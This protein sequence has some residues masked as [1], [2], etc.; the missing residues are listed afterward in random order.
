MTTV[1]V[2][3]STDAS[4]PTLT[5]QAG[6]LTTLL[7]AVLVNGYGSQPAAGWT[8]AF[9]TTSK[10][11]YRVSAVDGT[12]FYLNVDDSAVTTAKEAY[13]T[14]FETMSAFAT[15]TG[16]FPT[17]SLLNLG[18]SPAGAVVCRKSTT[19][20]STARA[21]TIV[22]DDTC[23]YLFAETGDNTSPLQTFP[24]MFGDIFSYKSSDAYRCMIIGRNIANSA[25]LMNEGFAQL[26]STNVNFLTLTM[27]GHYM[28]R[29]WTTAG[30][31]IPFGK[32][33]DHG[34]MGCFGS[35]LS[36]TGTSILTEIGV[37]SFV[38]QIGANSIGP[39]VLAYPNGP[40]GGLYLSPI[41][42]HHSGS[43]R[44]YLK[45]LWAPLHDRPLNHDDTYSGTGNLS[46]KSFVVQ[47][48][49]SSIPNG[50]GNVNTALAGQV[51]IETSS[52]WS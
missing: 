4:A 35:N 49:V 46:G 11:S 45:G 1:T 22:A 8:I 42:V 41:W 12:G 39:A 19:A 5:G 3:R 2:Y 51:H 37:G 43:V 48:I 21:W 33:I 40:D 7:D 16:Q 47:S 9:T 14:G 52:T 50:I 24:F 15:G 6:S 34:K 13:M 10:R 29:S 38:C 27:I 20:D 36:L 32:H 17:S 23:F 26:H 28:A 18:T 44:G 30:G 31:A 25:A